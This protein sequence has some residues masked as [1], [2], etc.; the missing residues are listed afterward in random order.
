MRFAKQS[1]AKALIHGEMKSVELC[2]AYILMSMYPVPERSWDRDLS[3][4][5][6]VL[7]SGV[8]IATCSFYSFDISTVLRPLY[9]WIKRQKSTQ[10]PRTRNVNLSIEFASGNYASILIEGQRYNLE[11]LG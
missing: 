5:I 11:G 8:F 9:A 2:Q 10:R 6:R 3:G 7:L 4:Y 1:A